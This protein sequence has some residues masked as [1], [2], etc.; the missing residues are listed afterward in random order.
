M[1]ACDNVHIAGSCYKD[2]TIFASFIQKD[3]LVA[4]HCSLKG[5]DGINFSYNNSG[6]HTACTLSTA[7]ANITVA[8]DNDDLTCDHD[9]SGAFD[10]VQEGLTAAVEIVKFALGAG[11]IYIESGDVE[12]SH[13]FTL[14]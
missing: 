5:V 12:S 10:S 14:K 9:V 1:L 11:V 6:S 8:A 3:N 4:F 7:F 13:F 2:V